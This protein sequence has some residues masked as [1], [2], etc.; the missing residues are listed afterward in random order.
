L[1]TFYI[2]K[3]ENPIAV[4]AAAIAKQSKA[5]QILISGP[6]V[7][8]QVRSAYLSDVSEEDFLKFCEFAY[9][10]DYSTPSHTIRAEMDLQSTV[11]DDCPPPVV[12]EQYPEESYPEEPPAAERPP[13]SIAAISMKRFGTK[14][15]ASLRKSFKEQSYCPVLPRQAFLDSCKIV[16]NHGNMEDY[17]PVFLAHARLYALAEK[18]GVESLKRLTLHKL[19]KTL[20][21]FTLYEQSIEDVVELIRFSYCNDHTPD[22]G[23]DELR[24]LVLKFVASRHDIIGESEPFLSLLE[25]GGVFVRDFWI[26]VRKQLIWDLG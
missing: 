18:Y 12:E 17:T 26:F 2:G 21:S 23:N 4:H 8:A 16:T 22:E 24:A 14:T 15:T 5:L 13:S 7:E 10:G 20:K 1:F 3:N 25:E 9:T 19:H 6:M 11:Y